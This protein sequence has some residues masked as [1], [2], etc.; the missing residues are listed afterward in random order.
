VST[1]TKGGFAQPALIGGAVSGALSALPIISAGNVCCCL[2][3]V[4]G[5]A[6]AAYL[7]QQ[8]RPAAIT[9]GDGALAGLMAGATGAFVYLLIS[10]PITILVAPMERIMVERIIDSGN[11]PP[12]YR[13]LIG[14]FAGSAAGLVFSFVFMLCI[15][16]VFST[17]GGVLGAAIF[18]K[19]T[20]PGTVV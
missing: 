4:T 15:G 5:G 18:K 20:P 2:W 19:Q 1:T 14:T 6:V 8:S 10:I 11:L 7:L 13:E 16:S 3:V 17:I 9:V 12:E